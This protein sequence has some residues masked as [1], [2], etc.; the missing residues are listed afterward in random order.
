MEILLVR[1]GRPA[2]LGKRLI[3]GH[4]LGGVLA[5]YNEAGLAEVAIP[6]LAV[7]KLVKSAGCVL[8]SDLARSIESAELLASIDVKIDPDLREAGLP[9]SIGVLFPIPARAWIVIARV[10][11][12]LNW[13]SSEESVAA[14]RARA[15]RAADR[16]CMLANE[17]ERVAVVGHGLFNRFVA[18][19][20]RR[21]GWRGPRFLPS[22]YWAAS[23]FTCERT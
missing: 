10:V 15:A 13:C 4:E 5:G 7:Q 17:Y 1:H 2:P 16:L 12:W 23:T 6:P 19:Q 18:R 3:S 11:W 9:S 22:A 21:R 14:T 20:L 8:A